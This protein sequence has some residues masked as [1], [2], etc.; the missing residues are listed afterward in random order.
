MFLLF[1]P[2][3]FPKLT[4]TTWTIPPFF[5][6]PQKG[7]LFVGWHRLLLHR[8]ASQVRGAIEVEWSG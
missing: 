3:T 5:L 7:G 4:W 6:S 1:F 2:G 8:V